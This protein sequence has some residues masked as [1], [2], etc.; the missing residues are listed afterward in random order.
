MTTLEESE[1]PSS[2]P[3]DK[4]FFGA[5]SSPLLSDISEEED[6]FKKNFGD[7]IA[8]QVKTTTLGKHDSAALPNTAKTFSDPKFARRQSQV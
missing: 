3:K 4:A 2:T 1:P 7:K 5:N 6:E 8:K